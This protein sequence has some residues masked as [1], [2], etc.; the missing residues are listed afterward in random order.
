MVLVTLLNMHM[1]I[2]QKM[3]NSNQA[4]RCLD[5]AV[6][7]AEKSQMLEPGQEGVAGMEGWFSLKSKI[8]LFMSKWFYRD[9]QYVNNLR[10]EL[11]WEED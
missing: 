1:Y 5:M 8:I 10:R 11:G 6:K 3:C 7:Y 2:Y 4:D 9:T